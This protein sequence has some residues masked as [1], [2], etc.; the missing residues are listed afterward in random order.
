MMDEKQLLS[1][2]AD[3]NVLPLESRWLLRGI[4]LGMKL[5]AEVEHSV[6]EEAIRCG[7]YLHPEKETAHS[8]AS[9]G[10]HG[11]YR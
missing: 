8:P 1:F 10:D 9:A 5:S 3:F 4:Q 11:A 6:K 2:A 7:L